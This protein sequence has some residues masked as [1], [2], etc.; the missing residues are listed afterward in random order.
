LQG[1]L[2]NISRWPTFNDHLLTCLNDD[3]FHLALL[4]GNVFYLQDN[5]DGDPPPD[6][7]I[8][9]YTE[10]E[11][12]VQPPKL[13]ADEIEYETFDKYLGAEF[14]L[15]NNNGEP[16]PA[17][18]VKHARDNDGKVIGKHHVNPLLEDSR[19]YECVLD[20]ESL[21]RYSVNVIAENIFAQCDDDGRRQAILSQITDHTKD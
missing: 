7:N 5:D 12:M 13:D 20:D 17:Q 8:P 2:Y 4:P 3:N 14:M 19:E 9:P 18:V 16:V 11:D 15:V 21:C 6:D 1:L 10:Y